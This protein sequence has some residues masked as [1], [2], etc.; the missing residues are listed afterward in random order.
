MAGQHQSGFPLKYKTFPYVL[1]EKGYFIGYTGKGCEPFN[2]ELFGWKNNPA[3]PE[4]DDIKYPESVFDTMQIRNNPAFKEKYSDYTANFKSF[5]K[6]KKAGQP[7]FFWFGAHEPHRI[8]NEG[9]GKRRNRDIN[10]V[11]PP[12]FLPDNETVKSDLM[13]Y[14]LEIEWFDHQLGQI[15][16]Y[17]KEIGEYENT[18]IIVTSDNGMAFP[19]AKANCYEYGIHVPLSIVW[20]GKIKPGKNEKTP[21][22]LTSIAPTL[23]NILNISDHKMLPFSGEDITGLLL[24]DNPDH[25][26]QNAV[27]AGRERHSVSRW[28][29]LGYPQRA[30]RT[31]KYLYILNL[32]PERL[33]AGSPQMMESDKPYMPYYNHGLNEQG[34]FTNAAYLD[35]DNGPTKTFFIENKDS[36]AVKD[37]FEMATSIRPFE[38]MYDIKSDQACLNNLADKPEYQVE[39]N[40]LKKQLLEFLKNTE[41]PRIVGPNPYVFDTYPTFHGIYIFPYQEPDWVKTKN[42]MKEILYK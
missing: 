17:L 2:Y 37:Y 6:E 13:D 9:E 36:P 34:R 7:F 27:F 33:P 12:G 25:E 26:K 3:G 5:F 38:E 14:A 40:I 21:V 42:E 29:N 10:L 4:F 22:S 31:E 28:M 1:Q 11:E 41:D 30:I 32:A 18:I 39:K 20:P 24:Q 23:F 35:I 15:I 8:F 16:Q 19:R